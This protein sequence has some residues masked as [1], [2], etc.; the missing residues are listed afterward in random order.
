MRLGQLG[1]TKGM[2]GDVPHCDHVVVHL[3]ELLL[4]GAEGVRGRV[5]LVGFEALVREADVEGFVIL[6]QAV[7]TEEG[8]RGDSPAER[9]R[10]RCVR[11]RRR[12]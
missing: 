1:W 2:H 3:L 11:R 6:L 4:G 12:W 10:D 7:R 9:S 5:E 8:W